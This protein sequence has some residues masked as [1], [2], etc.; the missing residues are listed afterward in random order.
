MSPAP[1]SA[2]PATQGPPG[3]APAARTGSSVLII[4]GASMF[5]AAVG[6]IVLFFA[7]RG[8]SL[9]DNAL[10]LSF[11]ALM[12]GM[13]AVTGG[14]QAETTRIVSLADLGSAQPPAPHATRPFWPAITWGV[15]LAGVGA[16]LAVTAGVI[17]STPPAMTAVTAGVIATAT[18]LY[19]GHSVTIGTL[20]A[21][22]RWRAFGGLITLEAVTRLLAMLAALLLGASLAGFEGAAALGA[23]AWLA[24]I[25]CSSSTRVAL[26]HRAPLS[27]HRIMLSY[28]AAIGTAVF[29]AVLMVAYPFAMQVLLPPEV[30]AGAAPLVLAISLTRAP[31]MIPLQALQGFLVTRF[32]SREGVRAR[33]LLRPCGLVLAAGI[34]SALAAALVGPPVLRLFGEHYLVSPLAFAGLTF[35]AAVLAALFFASTTALAQGHHRTY[36]ASWALAAATSL[37]LLLVPLPLESRVTVSLTAGPLLGLGAALLLLPRSTER[38]A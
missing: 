25:A 10:F 3:A 1:D 11:W 20:A 24:L 18:M 37:A 17:S 23:A 33:D 27:F 35:A 7:A 5:S 13:F 28:Q 15:V 8:L 31:I 29:M 36:V 38:A 9:A 22:G 19:S 34:V 12:S 26:G 2:A 4:T 6:F 16:L 21:K 14:M 32:V 30:Y